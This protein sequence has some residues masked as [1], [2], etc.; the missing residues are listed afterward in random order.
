MIIGSVEEVRARI[1]AI[2]QGLRAVSRSDFA[3][4]LDTIAPSAR[5]ERIGTS[6]TRISAANPER[7]ARIAE[8]M[9]SRNFNPSLAS[10]AE[11]FATAAAAYG[12]DW[13]LAPALATIESSGGRFCFRPNNPFGIMGRDFASFREA[14]YEVNRLVRSYGFG[15]D[16]RAILAKYNPS[17][18]EGYI[19]KV[20][21]EMERM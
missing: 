4:L 8:Y 5:N 11:S 1:C 3:S 18:G 14:I 16:I 6:G 17:G 15:N 19:R 21:N 10:E 12:M 7:A 13:R 2:E 9:R 20:I